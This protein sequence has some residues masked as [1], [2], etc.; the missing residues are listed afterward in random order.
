MSDSTNDPLDNSSNK[1]AEEM[2]AEDTAKKE[3][4]SI[5]EQEV[6][7]T[8]EEEYD[9]TDYSTDYYMNFICKPPLLPHEDLAAFDK[10]VDDI[11]ENSSFVVKT[12]MEHFLVT[13]VI[14]LMHNLTRYEAMKVALMQSQKRPVLEDLFMK[15]EDPTAMDPAAAKGLAFKNAGMWFANP[16]FRASAAKGFEAAGYSPNAIE[17]EA[18]QRSLPS[19]STLDRLIASAQKRVLTLM[20]ELEKRCRDREAE[21]RE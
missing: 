15:T 3:V 11:K 20:K 5:A 19:L 16:E 18:F 8:V 7:A 6:E 1:P 14:T 12:P 2:P 17:V 21:E 13:Q 4:V 9:D 10:L